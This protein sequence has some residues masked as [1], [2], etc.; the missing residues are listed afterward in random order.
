[1]A[2]IDLNADVGESFGRWTL[3]DDA[4]LMRS[5]SSANI[6][7]GFHAGDPAT[8]RRT[9]AIA[10]QH[11]VTIGAHVSYHDL[12]G[13]GRRFIEISPSDLAADVLYQLGALS[14]MATAAGG[15]VR[16]VKPHGALYH[17]VTDHRDQAAAVVA[18]TA[19]FDPSLTVLAFPDSIILRLA[20]AAGLGT[21]TEAFADRRY[22]D[23]RLVDRSE[24]DAVIT[25][26]DEVCDAA[27]AWAT[28]GTADSL[29]L[30]GD[31]P[32]AA[33]LASRVRARL[34][35]AGVAVQPFAGR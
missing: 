25:D 32:G 21:A 35:A 5:I 12:P 33:A 15:S 31:T 30:H 14:G 29:C 19:A 18:A 17:A 2:T 23:S 7:C 22:R 16:Y 13:F 27:L 24:S 6:A 28:G 3:G 10:V 8:M 20:A 9:C 11:G 34:A 4:A 1:M 26:A